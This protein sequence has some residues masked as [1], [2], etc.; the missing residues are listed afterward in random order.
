VCCVILCLYD[1]YILH[2]SPERVLRVVR[3]DYHSLV[4]IQDDPSNHFWRHGI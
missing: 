1:C 2:M 3:Q 4:E